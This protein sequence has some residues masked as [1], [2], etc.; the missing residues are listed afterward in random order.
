MTLVPSVSAPVLSSQR[1]RVGISTPS[2]RPP[3]EIR[4]RRLAN[5]RPPSRGLCAEVRVANQV[6][7][8]SLQFLNDMERSA[9]K[10]PP[11]PMP[12]K[13]PPIG[14]RRAG[15]QSTEMLNDIS[16]MLKSKEELYSAGG[17][18][19]AV[20]PAAAEKKEDKSKPKSK[21]KRELRPEP[22]PGGSRITSR[23]EAKLY[24]R[25]ML[26]EL[27]VDEYK[28]QQFEVR[29]SNIL[30]EQDKGVH[31][32]KIKE[33]A[34]AVSLSCEAYVEAIRRKRE[35]RFQ[36]EIEKAHKVGEQRALV[37]E[38]KLAQTV[39]RSQFWEHER[40]E[41][42]RHE[43]HEAILRRALAWAAVVQLIA[44]SQHM[45]NVMVTSRSRKQELK[46]KIAGATK[47]LLMWRM[48]IFKRRLKGLRQA[49]RLMRPLVF[50]W[51]FNYRIRMK[52]RAAATLREY[53]TE[54]SKCS[55]FQSSVKKYVHSVRKLQQ[56]WRESWRLIKMQLHICSMWWIHADEK[57]GLSRTAAVHM[58]QRERKERLDILRL[59]LRE[60]K[61]EHF[62]R[63]ARWR[64]ERKDYDEWVV[65]EQVYIEARKLL[66]SDANGFAAPEHVQRRPP[67][68]PI[69]TLFGPLGHFRLLQEKMDNKRQADKR[70]ADKEWARQDSM[71]LDAESSPAGS[72]AAGGAEP[73]NPKQAPPRQ[74]RRSNSMNMTADAPA[75]S[76]SSVVENDDEVSVS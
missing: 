6:V 50:W 62:I 72:P 5:V 53:L 9:S 29:V 25:S 1:S 65:A 48:Y 14:G 70:K 19:A 60:R 24:V 30:A 68:R 69:F 37:D 26:A 11:P 47:L 76:L 61:A 63:L 22:P 39:A 52:R 23:S 59:D 41:R 64:R 16:A 66:S 51:R 36:K 17:K 12:A 46:L 55:R 2:L 15:P 54:R 28:R 21:S 75:G 57:R 43:R 74:L 38:A 71:R 33:N 42:L 3:T 67:P 45:G 10:A 73:P 56:A 13:L 49:R 35:E 18:V 58:E 40:E 34:S 44:R 8:N 4:V 20:K 31:T 7:S 32:E 27:R